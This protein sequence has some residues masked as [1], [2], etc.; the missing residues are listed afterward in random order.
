MMLLLR[1]EKNTDEHDQQREAREQEILGGPSGSDPAPCG[2][3]AGA[4][5]L[6]VCALCA[7]QRRG[8][9][10]RRL[11]R[12]HN[13]GSGLILFPAAY[14]PKRMRVLMDARRYAAVRTFGLVLY[15]VLYGT[16]IFW[17][18]TSCPTTSPA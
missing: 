3:G 4:L 7:A 16:Y 1:D 5:R 17:A 10:G 9:S 13:S 11:F 6:F 2:M 18:P 8:L 14:G 12:R 15:V